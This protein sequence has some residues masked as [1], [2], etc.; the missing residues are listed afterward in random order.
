MKK[1]V[2]AQVSFEFMMFVAISFVVLIIFVTGTTNKISEL[3]KE[4][5]KIALD[6]VAY[7][8]Q[9]EL[10]IAYDTHDGYRREFT[11]PYSVENKNINYD[12]DNTSSGYFVF[13]NTENHMSVV[14]VPHFVGTISNGTNF[15]KKT[16]GVINVSQTP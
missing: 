10:Y 13:L 2:K 16:G 8:L 11:L 6:D 4:K 12:Y 14:S 9:S 3:R 7:Y 1:G 15:I 5:E